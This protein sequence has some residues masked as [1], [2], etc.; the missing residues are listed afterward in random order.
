M[1]NTDT[2]T[3]IQHSQGAEFTS[4]VCYAMIRALSCH[5]LR[6][7]P[8]FQL[9]F[10]CRS[11]SNSFW[12]KRESTEITETIRMATVHQFGPHKS[13]GSVL[14]SW[15]TYKHTHALQASDVNHSPVEKSKTKQNKGWSP[16]PVVVSTNPPTHTPAPLSGP[17]GSSGRTH[18]PSVIC[19]SSSVGGA[20]VCGQPLRLQ[21]HWM[22]A[23]HCSC[24]MPLKGLLFLEGRGPHTQSTMSLFS[25]F[26][27]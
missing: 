11:W 2:L 16:V 6:L 4:S 12:K 3:H 19:H 15:Q 26:S 27:P 20:A 23:L 18:L 7:L 21:L 9:L 1:T 5:H 10:L 17:A 8:V 14:Q 24:L 22:V 13:P 25:F